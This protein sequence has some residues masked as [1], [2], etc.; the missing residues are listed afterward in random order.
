LEAAVLVGAAV[1]K[2]CRVAIEDSRAHFP[3]GVF[4]SR[5]WR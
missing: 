2:E 4:K 3:G 5:K 1:V